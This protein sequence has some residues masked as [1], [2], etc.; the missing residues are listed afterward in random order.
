MFSS[1]LVLLNLIFQTYLSQTSFHG[2]NT[3]GPYTISENAIFIGT[4]SVFADNALVDRDQYA[5][6]YNQGLITFR[7]IVWDSVMITVKF[8]AVPFSI[9]EKHGQQ[10]LVKV[11]TLDT[12]IPQPKIIRDSIS[13]AADG[14]LEFI[15]SK[16]I[17]VDVGSKQGL[18]LDQATRIDIK[19]NLSG[20]NVWAMLSD[21]GNPIPA[22][23]TTRELAEFDKIQIKVQAEKF[24]GY[25][26]DND[27]MHALG[28]IG[29]ISK[30]LTGVLFDLNFG[31]NTTNLGYAKSKG[32]FKRKVFFGENNKQGP[33]YLTK[34]MDNAAIVPGT[35]NVYL[36]SKRLVRGENEDYTADYAGGSITFTNQNIVNSFS[37]IEID[38]EYTTEAYNRYLIS[39][40][41]EW[42]LN[43]NF[44]LQFGAVS[45]QDDKSRNLAYDLSPSDIES[46]STVNGESSRVWL[47]GVK[48]VGAGNGDYMLADNN[49]VFAGID[50]GDYDIRFS[51]AG[52]NLGD[53][54]YDNSIA[55]FRYVGPNQGKYVAKIRVQLPEE[56]RIYNANCKWQTPL[57]LKIDL[58][59]FW[60][61]R[62]QNLF[63]ENGFQGGLAYNIAADYEKEKYRV[64]YERRELEKRFYFPYA[65]DE[66]DFTY[67]WQDI[68]P[69]SLRQRDRLDF[70]IRPFDFILL[71]GGG[72]W[73]NTFDKVKYERYF[74]GGKFYSHQDYTVLEWK[75][76]HYPQ[77]ENRYYLKLTPRYKILYP[78]CEFFW[79]DRK[80]SLD[81]YLKPSLRVKYNEEI[82][83]KIEVDLKETRQAARKEHQVYKIQA[84]LNKSIISLNAITGYQINR[85]DNIQEN[86]DWFANIFSRIKPMPGLDITADY[87]QQQSEIQTMELNYVWVGAGLGNYQRNP[88]TDEY[89]YDLNGDYV[90]Q[91]IPSGNFSINDLRKLQANWDFY[92]WP[93]LN[94]DGY[95]VL[96]FENRGQINLENTRNNRFL[97]LSILPFQ[98][99]FSV[100]MNNY[101]DYTRDDRFPA[102][103]AMRTV[104]NNRIEM[105]LQ[106]TDQLPLVCA[107]EDNNQV[108][109]KIDQ[110]IEEKRRD[111]IF[112]VKSKVGFN[113]DFEVTLIYARA[114]IS[115]PLNYSQLG[116]FGL[117]KWEL[118]VDKKWQIDKF[119]NLSTN[120]SA[121]QRSATIA[122][123][124]Y[125]INLSE[126]KGV[127]PQIRIGIDR[128]FDSAAFNQVMLNALYTYRK[129]PDRTGEHN[130]STKLQVNF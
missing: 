25:Y 77:T 129:Y 52:A 51:Y 57:G 96:D 5:L 49:F 73:L 31:K 101:F 29:T 107:Y 61:Q 110:S 114:R 113:L 80:D 35:E 24:T 97:N 90:Q 117:N 30:K 9:K 111:R 88:E 104:N 121:A 120:F 16:T 3:T 10:V 85:S 86:G 118:A 21:V 78:G 95:Y 8:R 36:N 53:Y 2:N 27:Y 83:F 40:N 82:D 115:K 84:G 14:D 105:H 116:E 17:S 7:E 112:S 67:I 109:E 12:V 20:V 94:F 74:Y 130:F 102:F 44:S 76:S 100:K 93:L 19:G 66:I 13:G 46:L 99:S 126:P 71:S 45:E 28:N 65:G 59:G 70:E 22:E 54:D 127:T 18:G 68:T 64:R 79:Q 124:P 60:S 91:L 119:S 15:G 43:K 41:H 4:D 38:F 98:K 125:D 33:Y 128:I 1:G 103:A 32:V 42:K 62:K 34:D 47:S 26:G 89:Y 39:A 108:T 92:K 6:D 37:R 72:D 63:S 106:K 123:L 81:R 56:N 23:G 58:L 122:S 75:I 48:F 55:G 11:D 69:E 50:S 87:L